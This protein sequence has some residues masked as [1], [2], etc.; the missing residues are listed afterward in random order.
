SPCSSCSPRAPRPK[1]PTERATV[2]LRGDRAT[3]R[4]GTAFHTIRF[5]ATC[6]RRARRAGREKALRRA[7]RAREAAGPLLAASRPTMSRTPAFRRLRES[8]LER[9]LPPPPERFVFLGL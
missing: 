9:D 3:G 4:T 2:R 6:R 5:A 8:S 7:S 1:G